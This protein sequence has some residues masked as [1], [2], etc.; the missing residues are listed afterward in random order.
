[1]ASVVKW[2]T[3]RFVVPSFAGSIPVTRPIFYLKSIM[4]ILKTIITESEKNTLSLGRKI[5]SLL[6]GSNLIILKGDLGSGKT[7]LVKG[8]GRALK[9]KEEITSP[10]Y[11]YKREY[12]GLV[13]YDL[14]LSE[15]M[16]SKNLQSLISEDLE[17]NLVIVEWGDKLPKIKNSIIIEIEVI[18]EKARI[19]KIKKV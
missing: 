7:V 15:K 11:G 8:I 14:Y 5:L 4:Q 12:K 18:S 19:I 6:K 3:Q 10:T 9:I 16:S 17:D 2:L 13:H 1:M